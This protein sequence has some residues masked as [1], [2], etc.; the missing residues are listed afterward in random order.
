MPLEIRPFRPDEAGALRAIRLEAL[1]AHPPAFAERHDVALA[2]GG[3]DFAAALAEG[4][5]FGVWE[6]E[7]C[8]GMAG[9]DR[10]RGSNVRHKAVIWGV[11]L[12]P[13]ARGRGAGEALFQAM[14][15]HARAIGI[16]VLQ[17]GVG[18]FNHHAQALYRRMGF[19]PFGLEPRAVKLHDRFIDEV[20]MALIL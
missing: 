19:V 1:A 16:E 12:S 7:A 3:E 5:V 9:L 14:I 6:G 15:D 2:M 20:L 13:A 11:Y 18:D 10:W 17:L 4:A 8:L